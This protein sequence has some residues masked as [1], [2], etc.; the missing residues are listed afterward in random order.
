MACVAGTCLLTWEV[1]DGVTS[2]EGTYIDKLYGV[3]LIGTKVLDP[4]PVLLLDHTDRLTAISSNG[5]DYMVM[6]DRWIVCPGPLICGDDVIVGRVTGDL[7]ALDVG[8]QLR[9]K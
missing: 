4:K 5:Q 6:V 8:R 7:Q 2:A 3:R 9:R 1:R